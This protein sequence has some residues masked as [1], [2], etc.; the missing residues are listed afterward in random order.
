MGL[1]SSLLKALSSERII[2]GFGRGR[3]ER[4]WWKI[5]GFIALATGGQL[6]VVGESHCQ[7]T[8]ETIVENRYE[9]GVYWHVVAQLLFIDDHPHDPNAIGVAV[10]GPPAGY[11]PAAK[12]IAMR[13]A[14][15]AINP[16]RLP[17]ICKGEITG[18]FTRPKSR[19]SYGLTLDI[20]EPLRVKTR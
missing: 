19:G 16:E 12:A 15:L 13:K 18:G 11:I 5:D 2:A 9:G 7:S 20:V 6:S 4:G 8:F 14:I 3:L 17:V 10:N 1:L